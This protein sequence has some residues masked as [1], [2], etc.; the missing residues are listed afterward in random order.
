M[1]RFVFDLRIDPETWLDYYRGPTR[2][3]VARSRDGRRVQFAAKH[4]QRFVT[5]GGIQGTFVMVV[6]DNHDLVSFDRLT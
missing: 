3:V 5:R 1:Q 2:N 4:L 6:D